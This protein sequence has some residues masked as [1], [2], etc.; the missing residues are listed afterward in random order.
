MKKLLISH[1]YPNEGE[2]TVGHGGEGT[3]GHGGGGT[4]GHGGG[5]EN[6]I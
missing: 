5:L 1:F 6:G 2:G 3:V 4:V